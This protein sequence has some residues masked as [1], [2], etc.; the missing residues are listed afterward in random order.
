[1]CFLGLLLS[2]KFIK[3]VGHVRVNSRTAGYKTS[4]ASVLIG[5]H[6]RL[7]VQTH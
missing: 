4:L 6:I 3:A 5:K 7:D 1:M 2:I